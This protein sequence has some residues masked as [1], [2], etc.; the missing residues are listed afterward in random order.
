MGRN[1]VGFAYACSH[2]TLL[3]FL[4][5]PCASLHSLEL[6]ARLLTSGS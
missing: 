1:G 4:H 3:D 5:R 6:G 2:P